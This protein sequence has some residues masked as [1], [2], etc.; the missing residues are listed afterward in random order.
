MFND[1]FSGWQLAMAILE[2][3][4]LYPP[5]TFVIRQALQDIDFK[6]IMI[7][8]DMNIQIPIPALQ[9]S[10]QLWGPDAH[11]FNPESFA[12]GIVEASKVPQAYMPFGIGA[13]IC[14]GQ[15]LAMELKV[16]LSLLLSKFCF[17]LSP[18]YIHSPAFRLVIQPEHGVHLLIKKV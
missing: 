17:S 7:P 13:R 18:A 6:G 14:T 9:Q 3:L 10:L 2:I 8:K 1:C 16:A 4:R 15:H 5:A 12:N 11:R